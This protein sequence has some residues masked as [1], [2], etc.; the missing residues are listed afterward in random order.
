MKVPVSAFQLCKVQNPSLPSASTWLLLFGVSHCSRIMCMYYFRALAVGKLLV[1]KSGLREALTI[2][3]L[4]C[5]WKCR[6]LPEMVTFKF[7]YLPIVAAQGMLESQT[8][9][10]SVWNNL[11]LYSYKS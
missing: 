4:R 8:S 5:C 9:I 11:S 10:V 3:F 1:G 6:P 7:K 2:T